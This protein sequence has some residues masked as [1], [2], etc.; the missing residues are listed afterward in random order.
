MSVAAGGRSTSAVRD[1][2]PRELTRVLYE[3]HGQRVFTF[4]LSRLRNRE[5]AQDATQTTFMYAMRSIER[6]VVPEFEL[7]WL[8]KIAFNA[9][10]ALRRSAGTRPTAMGDAAE[11]GDPAAED[12]AANQE[13][14]NGLREALATLPETQRHAILLREW[15]GLSYAD[16][17]HEL[18]LSVSAVETLLFR[19][20]RN[21]AKRMEKTRSVR[22]LDLAS[23]LVF[24]R[25]AVPGSG[26][27]LAAAAAATGLSIAVAPA[28]VQEV[29]GA[30]A[31]P[32]VPVKAVATHTART[33]KRP[34][35]SSRL[36][37]LLGRR[38]RT[39]ASP[40]PRHLPEASPARGS[41]PKQP[42][43]E[44]AKANPP[45]SAAPTVPDTRVTVPA[46]PRAV[47]VQPPT[48]PVS[49]PALPDPVRQVVDALPQPQLP[50]VPDVGE[51]PLG[52]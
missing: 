15:Q 1:T 4:C 41:I 45:A 16:I 32:A 2:E 48:L 10:R 42:G 47:T 21:L 29:R 50:A 39:K 18:N 25:S 33:V 35:R 6:G 31:A 8:L 37:Q 22:A 13:R 28:L 20:R 46:P 3:R 14:L 52:K 34:A 30:E 49:P 51:L 38:A 5:E 26:A 7:A 24:L 36:T 40:T 19:A 11:I 9:C 44:P 17:A 23:P 43:T 27:K 12:A